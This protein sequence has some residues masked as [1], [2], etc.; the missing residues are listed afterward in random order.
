[1]S[2]VCC[3]QAYIEKQKFMRFLP[4]CLAFIFLSPLKADYDAGLAA[5]QR[6][7]FETAYYEW[8]TVAESA[9]DSVPPSLMAE[10]CYALGMLYWVGQG[11]AQDSATSAHWLLR[12]AESGHPAAQTKLGYLYGSGQGVQQSDF[13]ALKWTQMA[14]N[15]GDVDAQYNLGVFYRDGQVAAQNSEL[16]LKWFHEAAGNGDQI[17]VG[18]LADY[19][20]YGW[21]GTSNVTTES[22]DAVNVPTGSQPV[23]SGSI[24]DELWIGQR[25]PQHFTIQVIALLSPV[26]LQ[27]FAEQNSEWG[28]FAI[29]QQRWKGQPLFVLLKGDYADIEQARAAAAGFPLGLQK[30]EELWIRKFIQVQGLLLDE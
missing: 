28:P 22:D 3:R 27:E 26:K 15:Q 20:K 19:A 14:A 8:L 2:N 30:R 10:S 7:D 17:S 23:A 18:V 11:V 12:A 16:A 24:E 4:I 9:P 21:P 29:Y 1:M 6:G 25:N 13:T 5:Y